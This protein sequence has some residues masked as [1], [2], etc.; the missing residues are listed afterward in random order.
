[1]FTQ[2][3]K[4]R[5]IILHRVCSFKMDLNW[6]KPCKSRS[7]AFQMN[8][9][10]NVSAPK[11]W[12]PTSIHISPVCSIVM[13]SHGC[14]VSSFCSRI[15]EHEGQW[16]VWG[17]LSWERRLFPLLLSGQPP[18]AS[19]FVSASDMPKLQLLI[20]SLWHDSEPGFYLQLEDRVEWLSAAGRKTGFVFGHVL[21]LPLSFSAVCIHSAALLKLTLMSYVVESCASM[22]MYVMPMPS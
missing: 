11:I 7:D 10:H 22:P 12:K 17:S 9:L 18:P 13:V 2:L 1:M 21:S 3:I 15:I 5:E 16:V 8:K 19:C 20:D 4:A 14:C 6:I